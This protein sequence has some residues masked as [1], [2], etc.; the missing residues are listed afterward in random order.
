MKLKHACQLIRALTRLTKRPCARVNESSS[1]WIFAITVFYNWMEIHYMWKHV[2]LSQGSASSETR[3][4]WSKRGVVVA[5]G[6]RDMII[7]TC[8]CVTFLPDY[9]V[10]WSSENPSNLIRISATVLQYRI[11][12]NFFFPAGACVVPGEGTVGGQGWGRV[13][14]NNVH[15]AFRRQK[16]QLFSQISLPEA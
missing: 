4:T 14:V 15:A 9:Q 1:L 11:Y 10:L 6:L 5:P 12:F 2:W 3:K 8:S 7:W 13:A 16:P